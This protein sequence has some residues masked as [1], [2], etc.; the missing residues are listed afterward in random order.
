MAYLWFK[1]LHIIGF[2][3]WFAGLFYLVRLFVYHAE[4]KEKGGTAL[5]VLHP[6]YSLME[7]R[8]YYIITWPGMLIT[9]IF[10]TAMVVLNP[11]ILT[12][13]LLIKI[14]LVFGLV[15]YHI[16]CRTLLIAFSKSENTPSNSILRLYNEVPTLLLVA[17]VLL[18]VMKNSL[19]AVTAFGLL[20]GLMVILMLG[21]KIYKRMR[22]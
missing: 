5:D 20:A 18:A 14:A 21:I 7:W 19:N 15:L 2:V 10:G 16:Y 4:A 6:Q 1:S 3:T 12:Q 9:L 22:N 17:I 13:W 8:L 11:A